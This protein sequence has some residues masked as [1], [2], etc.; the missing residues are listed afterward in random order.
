MAGG[1]QVKPQHHNP[2][3]KPLFTTQNRTSCLFCKNRLAICQQGV[4][5]SLRLR[6]RLLM[7]PLLKLFF[8]LM[9]VRPALQLSQRAMPLKSKDHGELA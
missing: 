6:A 5:I 4:I 9:P 8:P 1:S 2:Y 3:V 7:T